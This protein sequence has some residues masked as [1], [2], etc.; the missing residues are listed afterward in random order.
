M[1]R[2]LFLSDKSR[3]VLKYLLKIKTKTKNGTQIEIQMIKVLE[4]LRMVDYVI[5]YITDFNLKI[6]K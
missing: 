5:L 1:Q 6:K 4:V 3:T 2:F